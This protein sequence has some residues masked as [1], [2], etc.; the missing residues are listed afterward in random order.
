MVA[1]DRRLRYES[2]VRTGQEKHRREKQCIHTRHIILLRRRVEMEIVEGSW[3]ESE[4]ESNKAGRSTTRSTE[5]RTQQQESRRF[6]AHRKEP[7]IS[8]EV[9]EKRGKERKDD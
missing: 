1:Q 5:R 3:R 9:R 6:G 7:G 8:E 2:L 4:S